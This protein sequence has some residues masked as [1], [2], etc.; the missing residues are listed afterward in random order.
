MTKPTSNPVMAPAIFGSSIVA[1]ITTAP[2]PQIRALGPIGLNSQ[3]LTKCPA[4]Q[5]IN[6]PTETMKKKLADSRQPEV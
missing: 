2:S 5:P 4:S 6:E 3:E 1:E